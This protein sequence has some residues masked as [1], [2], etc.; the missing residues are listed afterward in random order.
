[1]ARSVLP[2]QDRRAS[3]RSKGSA[4]R[5]KR[6][7]VRA[8]V[9]PVVHFLLGLPELHGRRVL[10]GLSGGADSVALLHALTA[11]RGRF[12]F[13]L[14]AA[15][16]NH[17]LRGAESERDEKFVRELCAGS[18]VELIVERAH[19]LEKVRT[20]LEARARAVR[21]TFLA[22]TAERI[23]AGYIALAHQA[24][25]Q[26]ETVMLRLLR[27]AGVKGLGAMAPIGAGKLIRP[28]LEVPRIAVLD[29]LGAIGGTFV[30]DSSNA[31]MR[32]DRNRVRKQLMPMLEREY[33]PALGRRLGE[34]AAEMRQLDELLGALAEQAGDQC[35]NQDGTLDVERLTGLH[36]AVAAALMRRYVADVVGNLHGF[37]R[38]HITALCNLARSELPNGQIALPFSW[39][40]RRRYGKLLL[41]KTD[42][43]N[44]VAP[45]FEVALATEGLTVVEPA[46]T[47]F[48]SE[49]V[50][51]R[52]P[53]LPQDAAEAMFDAHALGAGLFARN[54][55]PGDRITPFGM[56]GSRKVKDVFIEHKIPSDQRRRFPV[57]LLEGRVAW[58]PGLVRSNLAPVTA[59]TTEIVR[60]TAAS[61]RCLGFSP[62]DSV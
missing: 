41:L 26:A 53:P 47:I 50:C 16:L 3:G 43:H 17:G 9:D 29:Y 46:C 14:T 7:A 19:G 34:L 12:Q 1:M 55:N 15:H 52:L 57:V 30:E 5:S 22:A 58:L 8:L 39:L 32:H 6:A 40:G 56:A 4:G 44:D 60:L 27:G 35:V 10:L 36:P 21:H 24:D 23:G 31:S 54:F 62:R 42:K 13:E 59:E 45:T 37:D 2:M 11:L 20:N 48:H 33:A 18:G 61:G 51:H 25:D 49:L 28:M 38:S